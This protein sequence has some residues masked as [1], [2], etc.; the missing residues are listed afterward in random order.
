MKEQVKNIRT[1][2]KEAKDYQCL[3]EFQSKSA[4]RIQIPVSVVSPL[5][6]VQSY[7]FRR[8]RP[9]ICVALH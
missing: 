2:V 8:Q 1:E 7:L 4:E 6:S 3:F 5:L 9:V